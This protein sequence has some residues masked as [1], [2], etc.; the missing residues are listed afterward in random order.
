MLL[1]QGQNRTPAIGP[2]G[3]AGGLAE[4]WAMGEPGT[5]LAIERASVGHSPPKAL[6][7]QFLSQST[8]GCVVGGM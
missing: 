6:R 3:I 5:H 8:L 1:C 7:A 4:T 2:S